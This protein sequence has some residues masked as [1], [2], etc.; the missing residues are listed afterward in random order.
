MDDMQGGETGRERSFQGVADLSYEVNFIRAI[1]EIRD[2][3][4]KKNADD[5]DSSDDADFDSLINF[6]E[7]DRALDGWQI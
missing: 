3:R 5:T 7:F 1:R 6:G 2:I 4:G